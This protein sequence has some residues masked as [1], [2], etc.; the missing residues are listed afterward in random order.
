MSKIWTKALCVLS[1]VVLAQLSGIAG[2]QEKTVTITASSNAGKMM[3]APATLSREA[4]L[5]AKPIDSSI[6]IGK[7]KPREMS[8]EEKAALQAAKPELSDGGAPNS[9]AD[10]EARRDFSDEW[11]TMDQDQR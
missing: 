5:A 10:D 3:A 8:A 7:V 11:K 6:T 4:R 1:G 2:A 9:S